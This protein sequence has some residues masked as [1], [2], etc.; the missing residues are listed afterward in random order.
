M[1][2]SKNTHPL[3]LVAAVCVTLASLTAIAFFAGLLPLKKDASYLQ[4]TSIPLAP[5]TN[6]LVTSTTQTTLAA[7]ATASPSSKPE[8]QPL[9]KKVQSHP[10]PAPTVSLPP[11]R[12]VIYETR[13]SRTRQYDDDPDYRPFHR[14]REDRRQI[15]IMA[16]P[17]VCRE[18]GT[19]ESIHEISRKGEASGAGA[20]AGGV[21]GGVLGHQVGKGSGK[22]AATIVGVIG[23][24]LGG[25]HIEKNIRTEKQYQVTVRFDDGA[26]R[27]YTETHP[28]WQ[29]GQRVR[30][31]NG[32]LS[33][34]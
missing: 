12:E 13:Y 31:I 32:G 9:S 27:T 5:S 3:I 15:P 22:D 2:D 23:G 26:L 17:P 21:L 20:V 33:P 7:P 8:P 34:L 25:N 11:S 6:N 28:N 4:A 19:V 14:D 1:E 24:A 30:S 29:A 16:S 10:K 18:C